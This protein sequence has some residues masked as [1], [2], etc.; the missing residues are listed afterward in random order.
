M[1]NTYGLCK[2]PKCGDFMEFHMTYN[3]G[4][5]SIFY[6]CSCGFDTRNNYTI[7][8]NKTTLNKTSQYSATTVLY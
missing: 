1:Y 7:Y 6:T 2:C 4:Q 3:C 5:P 8:S